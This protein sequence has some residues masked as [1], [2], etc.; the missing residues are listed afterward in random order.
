MN[1]MTCSDNDNDSN[2]HNDI[3]MEMIKTNQPLASC[4]IHLSSIFSVYIKINK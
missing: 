2:D 3:S 1:R 4:N